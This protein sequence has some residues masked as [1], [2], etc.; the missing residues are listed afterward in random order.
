MFIQEQLLFLADLPEPF[1]P[2]DPF[3][4]V[5]DRPTDEAVSEWSLP[6][7]ALTSW[8]ATE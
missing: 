5:H 6:V 1:D 4:S 2:N 8:L 3:Q 7:A